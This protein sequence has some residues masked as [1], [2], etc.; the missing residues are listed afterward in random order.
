MAKGLYP[1]ESKIAAA[2]RNAVGG[3]RKR[4]LKGKNCSAACIA[5]NM[6]C[7]V[8]LPWVGPALSSAKKMIQ[9]KAQGKSAPTP[10]VKTTSTGKTPAPAPTSPASTPAAK[11]QA[12]PSWE[13][14]NAVKNMTPVSS[15]EQEKQLKFNLKVAKNKGTQEEIDAAKKALK[16]FQTAQKAAQPKKPAA[17]ASA[18]TSKVPANV[19]VLPVENYKKMGLVFLK[20][21]AL[22]AAEKY[23][24]DPKIKPI[25]RNMKAAIKE[26]EQEQLAAA[27]AAKPATKAAPKGKAKKTAVDKGPSVDQYK[28]WGV[29]ALETLLKDDVPNWPQ[30]SASTKKVIA[31][32]TEALKQL[33]AP[34]QTTAPAKPVAT[35]PAQQG[36]ATPKA[37]AKKAPTITTPPSNPTATN[38]TLQGNPP[39]PKFSPDQSANKSQKSTQANPQGLSP[40]QQKLWD[41]VFSGKPDYAFLQDYE[42]IGDSSYGNPFNKGTLKYE[43][44]NVIA[45]AQKISQALTQT[46][47]ALS[48]GVT[49]DKLPGFMKKAIASMGESKVKSGISDIKNFTGTNYTQLRAAQKGENDRYYKNMLPED[50]KKHMKTWGGKAA[51]MEKLMEFIPKPQ[52]P[53]F[54]GIAASD[55]QL[56]LF[57]DLASNKGT[58]VEKAMNSWST[59]TR[60]AKNFATSS[61]P[62]KNNKVIFR[63]LNKNGIPIQDVSKFATENEIL[64][65]S[66]SNYQFYSYTEVK[67]PFGG[68]YHIFDMVEY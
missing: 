55:A 19:K 21:T 5:A 38:T 37:K 49:Q 62:G 8:D 44:H 22:P 27:A 64:T 54:R 24:G 39:A 1:R 61:K 29:S 14:E 10:S 31:N 52:I 60:T 13:K 65:R 4:C 34:K 47:L 18:Q 3:K 20:D 7:L 12:K 57:K 35:S 48:L 46:S 36:T 41:S 9:S 66:N 58:L 40:N 17:P 43:M 42:P 16:D 63:T 68:T 67:S 53:K 2:K 23:S 6:V 25:L 26:L 30:N 56:A 15:L 32:A 50:I 28:T 33:K 59:D 51:K 11:P 45:K